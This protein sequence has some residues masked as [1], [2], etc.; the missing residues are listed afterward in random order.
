M[1]LFVKSAVVVIALSVSCASAVPVQGYVIAE[2]TRPHGVRF[3]FGPP[4][5]DALAWAVYD[6][7]LYFSTGWASFDLHTNP[8]ILNDTLTSYAAGYLE[9]EV[10][11]ALWSSLS[12]HLALAQDT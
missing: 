10:V 12:C 6:E 8:A 3:E 9:G 7:D 2:S 5:A 11:C 1:S 4:A